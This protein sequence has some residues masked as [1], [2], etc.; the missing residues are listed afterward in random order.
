MEA[1]LLFG[2]FDVLPKI[3]NDLFHDERRIIVRITTPA[4]ET[5]NSSRCQSVRHGQEVHGAGGMHKDE[6]R[7]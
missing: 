5:V 7:I 3:E 6:D 4:A 1:E 2:I